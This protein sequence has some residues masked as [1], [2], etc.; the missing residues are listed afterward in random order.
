[1]KIKEIQ[2]HRM[3]MWQKAVRENDPTGIPVRKNTGRPKLRFSSP[4]TDEDTAFVGMSKDEDTARSSSDSLL[5][6][7]RFV[8]RTTVMNSTDEAARAREAGR[9]VADRDRNAT[10]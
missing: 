4:P 8:R 3:D 7:E 1:M 5:A 10:K 9:L 2:Q 6:E